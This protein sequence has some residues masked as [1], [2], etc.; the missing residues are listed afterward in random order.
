MNP[1]YKEILG[2]A[3][4]VTVI[5]VDG[6]YVRNNIDLDFTEGGHDLVYPKIPKEQVWID[7]VLDAQE[8]LYTILHELHERSLMAR[9]AVYDYAHI[10]AN[11]AEELG[12]RD[13]AE[14]RNQ[15]RELGWHSKNA[16]KENVVNTIQ[17]RINEAKDV[18]VYKR[19]LAVLSAWSDK[20]PMTGIDGLL[21][22]VIEKG[23]AILPKDKRAMCILKHVLC[24][25]P[26][27]AAV[28]GVLNTRFSDLPADLKPVAKVGGRHEVAF[29]NVDGQ[30]YDYV[31]KLINFEGK[32]QAGFWCDISGEKVTLLD[33][34]EETKETK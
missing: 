16:T 9:G 23:K 33:T 32:K 17:E 22:L 28:N 11:R 34:E 25:E 14:L 21:D 8:R 30:V 3:G 18:N 6:E 19:L 10:N 29:W 4:P 27:S 1:P 24:V 7:D 13:E 26:F 31:K 20:F 2:Q 15:L 5:L 12:R